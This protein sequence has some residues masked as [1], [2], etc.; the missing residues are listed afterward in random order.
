MGP[1]GEGE[2]FNDGGNGFL[3]W[4][5]FIWDSKSHQESNYDNPWEQSWTRWGNGAMAYFYPPRKIGVPPELDLTVVPSLR[6][7][8]YRECVDEYEYAWMLERLIGRARQGG[9]DVSDQQRVLADLK[10]FF[11][12]RVHWSL[13]DAWY[14]ER[15]ERMARS[16][17]QLHSKGLSLRAQTLCVAPQYRYVPQKPG[18]YEWRWRPPSS[19]PPV[20]VVIS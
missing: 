5:S 15:R 8:T 10:R 13:N 14:L 2:V 4:A 19:L 20:V 7:M 9:L 11:V 6:L 17:E 12:G 18:R 3:M 1:S 16:I